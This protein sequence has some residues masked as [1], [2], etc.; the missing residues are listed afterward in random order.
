MTMNTVVIIGG[1][2]AGYQTAA[3]LRQQGFTGKVTVVNNEPGLPY[4][5]PPLSKGYLLGTLSAQHLL[6]RNEKWYASQDVEVLQGHAESIDREGRR[7]LLEDGTVLEYDHLVLATGARNRE[8]PVAG[9][10]LAGVF[11]M[12]TQADAD[13]VSERVRAAKN[14]VVI[15]AGFIGLEFASVAAKLGANVH[16]LELA[17]RPMARALS[18]T[19][20]QRFREAHEG[21]GVTLDFGSGLDH[22]EGENGEVRRVITSDGRALDADLVVY[23]IGVIPNTELAEAAGLEVSNGI[24][25]DALL[26]TSDPNISAV[27]DAVNFPCMQLDHTPTRLESVQN[28]ADQARALAAHLMGKSANYTALPWFWSDQGDL[29]LQIAGMSN[30]YDTIIELEVAEEKQMVVLCFKGDVLIAVET[31]NR[32]GEHMIARRILADA[33]ALTPEVA[34]APGFNLKEWEQSRAAVAVG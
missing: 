23:G 11:G 29:K 18:V 16:V 2:Q 4:Q 5:R 15:G 26:Q 22:I 32:P 17:D 1:G 6:H 19:T 31:V 3:S 20:S 13:A 12:K 21:W 24:V 14:V 8:L 27:G 25:V 9:A 7:V 34:S 28:A 10:E 30:G 33:P